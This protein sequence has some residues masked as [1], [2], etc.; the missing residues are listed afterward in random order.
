MSLFRLSF[1]APFLIGVVALAGCESFEASDSSASED[2]FGPEYSG[3]R[4]TVFGDGGLSL[5][6][7]EEP[8]NDGGVNV[9]LWRASLDTVSFMPVNSA[10][11]FGGVILT[12]WHSSA[13]APNERFKLNVYILGREL[14]ADGLRVTVFRQIFTR[15]GQ[16]ADAALPAET[17]TK[18]EDS[19]LTRA[20]QLR[21]TAILQKKQ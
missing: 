10:D 16:W 21:N 2:G 4:K 13:E 8:S 11:V 14:R 1:L 15:N 5:F 17:K 18:I 19:I 6:G 7:D 9:F 20:R 12:D 3:K